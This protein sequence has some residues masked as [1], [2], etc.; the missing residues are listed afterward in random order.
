[1]L[2]LSTLAITVAAT[3]CMDMADP[4]TSTD[5][6]A[7]PAADSTATDAIQP[8]VLSA[9]IHTAFVYFVDRGLTKRQAAGIVGNLMQESQVNPRAV[10][11]GGPGRG[12]AQWSVGG[13]WDRSS[14]D[15]VTEYA[16]N[17]HENR[18]TLGT[19]LAFTWHELASFPTYGLHDL[20]SRTTIAG[21]TI[22]FMS[23]FERCGDCLSSQRIAYAH[24]VFDAYAKTTASAADDAA[25]SDQDGDDA[26]D[27]ADVDANR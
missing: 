17:H 27:A 19:Q 8:D 21:A 1:M 22:A 3:G 24:E 12:I 25:D 15:N 14:G 16:N 11:P 13:R 4:S 20:R 5:P 26:A 9:N 18:W 6:S 2:S 23:D 7:D 10:E